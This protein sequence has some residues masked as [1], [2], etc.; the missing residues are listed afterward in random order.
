MLASCDRP[1]WNYQW[2][3]QQPLQIARRA[4]ASTASG[5]Y[6]YALGGVDAEG[7]YVN[8]VEFAHVLPDGRLEPWQFTTPLPAGR[9]YHAAVAVQGDLYILGGGQGELGDSN[10]PVATVEKAHILAAGRLGEWRQE[11]PLTTP[12]RGLQWWH[13]TTPCTRSAVTTAHF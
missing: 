6:L 5:D 10:T 4:L 12:R 13:I 9:I 11:T 1:A 2:E 7:R 3:D 8:T